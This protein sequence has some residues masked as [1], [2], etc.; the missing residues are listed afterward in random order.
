MTQKDQHLVSLKYKYRFQR[1]LTWTT[2]FCRGIALW[3]ILWLINPK[4]QPL[5]W[6]ADNATF[7][8]KLYK[9]IS[10]LFTATL[11]RKSTYINLHLQILQFGQTIPIISWDEIFFWGVNS[12]SGNSLVF[13]STCCKVQL[14]KTRKSFKKS[15]RRREEISIL[16]KIN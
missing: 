3:L 7:S 6:L 4:K 16:E 8:Q 15:W 10:I 2:K 12:L 5:A 1:K 13:L 11:T 9:G 14:C